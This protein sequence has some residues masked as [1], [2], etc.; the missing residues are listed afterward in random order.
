MK[1]KQEKKRLRLGKQTIQE[2]GK[3]L[4]KADQDRILGGSENCASWTTQVPVFCIP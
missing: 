1:N 3:V 2:L 4:D